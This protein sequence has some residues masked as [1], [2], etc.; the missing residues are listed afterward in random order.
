[1]KRALYNGKVVRPYLCCGSLGMDV[2]GGLRSWYR[3]RCWGCS[4][5][6]LVTQWITYHTMPHYGMAKEVQLGQSNERSKPTTKVIRLLR[7]TTT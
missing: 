3:H 7:L 2:D 5:G 1:M 6:N 4:Q